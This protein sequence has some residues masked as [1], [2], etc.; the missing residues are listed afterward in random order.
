[1]RQAESHYSEAR[2][3]SAIAEDG[4]SPEAVDGIHDYIADRCTQTLAARQRLTALLPVSARVER[5]G[6]TAVESPR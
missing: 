6:R 1:M 4:L 2:T 3:K 5:S